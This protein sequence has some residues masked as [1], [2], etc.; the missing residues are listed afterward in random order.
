MLSE[1]VL[2]RNSITI[3]C[4]KQ[5]GDKFSKLGDLII[6]INGNLEQILSYY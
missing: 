4:T 2:T 3:S 6:I 5:V 1:G